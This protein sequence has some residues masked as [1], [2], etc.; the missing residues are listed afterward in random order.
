MSYLTEI[1]CKTI[2]EAIKSEKI[3]QKAESEKE[4]DEDYVNINTVVN[5]FWTDLFANCFLV[6]ESSDGTETTRQVKNTLTHDDMLFFVSKLTNNENDKIEVYRRDSKKLPC[7]TDLNY[8]WEETVY[9]NLILHEF[10]YILTCAICTQASVKD[11][12]ILKKHSKRVYAS[13]SKRD[14]ESKG[15]EEVITYPNIYF[16]ID[17]FDEAFNEMVVKEG[18]MVCVEL[19]ANDGLTQKVLFIGSVKYE[20][21]KKVYDARAST[22]SKLVQRMSLGNFAQKRVEFVK[23][24]GPGAKGYAQMAVS[25]H[26]KPEY[27]SSTPG[28][29]QPATPMSDTY[30]PFDSIMNK[31]KKKTSVSSNRSGA[32]SLAVTPE[33]EARDFRQDMIDSHKNEGSFWGKTFGQAF[34]WINKQSNSQAQ[35]P[36]NEAE[37][38]FSVRTG[39]KS[40]AAAVAEKSSSNCVPLNAYLTYVTLNMQMIIKDVL[41]A[42]QRTLLI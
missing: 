18:E 7:L 35:E 33:I 23:M 40:A 38:S 11:L 10:E 31:F 15:T 24:R 29:S 14:L 30:D 12:E 4:K 2:L 9:L 21:L 42:N 22:G 3:K 28:S 20:A 6:T 13:P 17:D 32:S 16:M 37:S 19:V 26:Q 5:P 8:D 36:A 1:N 41:E 39:E 27:N 25:R 34:S